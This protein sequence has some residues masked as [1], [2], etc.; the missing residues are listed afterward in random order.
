MYEG[1]LASA[2]RY[3][4]LHPV[5]AGLAGRAADWPWSSVTAHLSGRDDTLVSVRPVLDRIP[6][7]GS[8][9]ESAEDEARTAALRAAET[10]GRPLGSET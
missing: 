1:H 4:S 9:L 10:I 8:L 2:V 6:N 3:I 7:F 5:R